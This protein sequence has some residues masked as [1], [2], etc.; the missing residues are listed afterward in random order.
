MS[1]CNF[2]ASALREIALVR[3]A[4]R[5]AAC[6][7]RD[8]AGADVAKAVPVIQ[9]RHRCSCILPLKQRTISDGIEEHPLLHS[10]GSS[11][12]SRAGYERKARRTRQRL[13]DLVALRA[14]PAASRFQICKT[15]FAAIGYACEPCSLSQ[16]GTWTPRARAAVSVSSETSP[17]SPHGKPSR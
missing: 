11:T 12:T 9:H 16:Y 15:R 17:G 2:E 3:L 6:R 4:T 1:W 5:V 7:N 13:I 8:I 14:S 10:L